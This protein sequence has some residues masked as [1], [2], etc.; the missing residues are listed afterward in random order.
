MTAKKPVAN[1]LVGGFT[2][3]KLAEIFGFTRKTTASFL[4]E[5]PILR[6]EGKRNFYE[7]AHAVRAYGNYMEKNAKP[8]SYAQEQA[9]SHKARREKLEYE[10]GIL[11]GKYV[12]FDLMAM[13]VTSMT[14][15]VKSKLRGMGTGLAPSLEGKKRKEIQDIINQRVEDSL[16]ELSD[17]F[18]EQVQPEVGG[19]MEA[20]DSEDG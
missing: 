13:N 12:D 5:C 8:S 18:G 11:K 10:T 14:A 1:S 4:H 20:A 9:L 19:A 15:S 17:F 6:K 2:V 3:T 16:N 7:L